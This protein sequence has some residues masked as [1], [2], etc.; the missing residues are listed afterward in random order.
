MKKIILFGGS[1]D[2]IHYGHL[3]IAKNALKETKADELW[4]LLAAIS[5]FKEES[6]AFEA[7]ETMLQMMLKD[8]DNLKICTIEKELPKPSYSIDTLKALKKKY[9]NVEFM[10]LIGSDQIEGLHQWKD[11]ET[12]EKTLEFIVYQRPGYEIKHPYQVIS[13]EMIDVSSTEIREGKSLQTKPEILKYMM[14]QNLYLKTLVKNRL[15]EYRYK[16]TIRV[17]NLALEIAEKHQLNLKKM[18]LIAMSHDLCKEDDENHLTYIMEKHFKDKTHL[19]KAFYHAYAA[20]Y[21]LH[22]D[23]HI[24][25]EDVLK[26]IENH[27]SGT[28]KNPYAMA[29]F[30]ADKCE[31]G[32]KY[33]VSEVLSLTMD[34]LEQGFNEVKRQN[35]QYLK[36]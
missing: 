27:V 13:G 28:S 33:N 10:W 8:E 2:P 17:K 14:E 31:P 32:R 26:A 24:D 9:T 5:P 1:F 3:E 22:S 11:F 4:F 35:E 18:K 6:S 16:H 19:H 12:L 36:E 30:I 23:Y 29:L 7:R 21:L 34:D 20:S 25:D 15:S